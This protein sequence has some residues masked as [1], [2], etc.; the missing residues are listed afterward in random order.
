MAKITINR[1]FEHLS[2][3][4]LRHALMVSQIAEDHT[5]KWSRT[6]NEMVIGN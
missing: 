2:A 5:M 6:D 1:P 3:D 4:A